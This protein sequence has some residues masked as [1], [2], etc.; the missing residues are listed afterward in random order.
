MKRFS[1]LVLLSA[2]SLPAFAAK[3]SGAA[4]NT[5]SVDRGALTQYLLGNANGADA[6]ARR[7]TIERQLDLQDRLLAEAEGLGIP[8]R[9]NVRAQAELERRRIVVAAY[10]D[11]WFSQHPIPEADLR[12]SYET[13][14]EANG[15]KQY[16]LSQIVVMNDA[17]AR[18]VLEDLKQ[19]K[20]FA[21][22][23]RARSADTGTKTRGG[24]IGWCWKSD[25]LPAV[26][27]VVDF[28]KPD[29]STTTPIALPSGLVV[30]KL[31]E[32]RQQA[33][34][35]FEALRP[36]LETALRFHVQKQAL[37]RLMVQSR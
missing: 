18:H 12:K 33:F 21:E 9:S 22:V 16:R 27:K 37:D 17:D 19:G 11:D 8:K 14:R 6:A 20:A 34:P 4:G 15:D 25:L 23:A 13:L 36:N 32:T 31:N 10:W 5:A 28:L 7:A 35:K 1:V 3:D 26:A 30:L 29:E 24:D 2:M